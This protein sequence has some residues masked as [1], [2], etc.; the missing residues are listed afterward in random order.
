MCVPFA[1]SI[2]CF[3]DDVLLSVENF[4]EKDLVVGNKKCLLSSLL[5]LMRRS[6]LFFC[7]ERLACKYAI[8]FCINNPHKTVPLP[9]EA[10]ECYATIIILLSHWIV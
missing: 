9:V 5:V 7:D 1:K 6:V 2:F 4:Y 10:R 8:S 3:S